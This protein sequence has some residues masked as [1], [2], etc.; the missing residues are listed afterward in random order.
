MARAT[1]VDTP[2][3]GRSAAGREEQAKEVRE[4]LGWAEQA[5]EAAA[6]AVTAGAFSGVAGEAEVAAAGVVAGGRVA[7]A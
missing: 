2:A 3:A 7:E 6:E 1:E 4:A 5:T